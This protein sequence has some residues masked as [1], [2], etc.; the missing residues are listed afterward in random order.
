M[1]ETMGTF[2]WGIF[3]TGAISGKFAAGLRTAGHQLAFVASRGE[4]GQRFA[5]AFG[6]GRAIQGYDAAATAA[7]ELAD[8]VYIATPPALHAE[9]ALGCIAAGVPV[10]VEK[11]FASDAA[12]ARAIVDAAGAARVF[13][14]EAMWTRFQPALARLKALVDSGAIGEPHM[15]SGSFGISNRVDPAYG[16]FDP[17]RGGGALAHLGYYPLSLGTFLFGTPA[18]AQAVGRIGETGVDEDVAI[19]LRYPSGVTGSFYTSLRSLGA[20][21]FAVHGTHGSLTLTGPIYRPTGIVHRPASPRGQ[22]APDFS[23]K[24]MLREGALYQRLARL[25]ARFA[26]G[27]KTEKL[28]SA[29]NGY[30]YQALAVATGVSA[31]ALESPVM[32]LAESLAVVETIDALRAQL[33]SRSA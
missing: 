8:A 33:R 6:A 12:G 14:M 10:L 19:A 15:V 13:A 22:P 20:D 31:G 18:E 4:A 17:T 9:H 16:N 7:R 25:R 23:R 24:S 26:S 11:P 2:R 21:D 27:G 32:P 30:H 29:G 1:G 28:P 3:G 5:S